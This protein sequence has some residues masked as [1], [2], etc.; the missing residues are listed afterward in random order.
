MGVAG[1]G[2]TWG[3]ASGSWGVMDGVE[4]TKLWLWQQWQEGCGHR[5]GVVWPRA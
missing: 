2:F 4:K 3:L 5:V 1:A